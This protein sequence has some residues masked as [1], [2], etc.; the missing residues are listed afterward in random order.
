MLETLVLNSIYLLFPFMLYIIC[1][2]YSSTLNKK[3]SCLLFMFFVI[4]SFYFLV[5]FGKPEISSLPLLLIIIPLL[6]SYTEK[7]LFTILLLNGLTF[8]YFDSIGFSFA[9]SISCLLLCFVLYFIFL[10]CKEKRTIFIIGF[11]V[12]NVIHLLSEVLINSILISPVEGIVYFASYIILPVL[13]VI[14]LEKLK[15]VVN[16]HNVLKTIQKEEK[17]RLSL[18]KITHE[19]K[20]PIAVCKGYLDML[21][22]SDVEQCQKYIPIVRSEI[23]RTLCLLKDFLDLNKVAIEKE[24]LDVGLLMEEIR[25]SCLPLLQ[26]KKIAYKDS[27]KDEDEIYLNGDYNRLKQ[28]FVNVIKNSIE[29]LEGRE[30]P[31]IEVDYACKNNKIHIIVSDNGCG[32]NKETLH[33][34][35]EPFF[36]TK[37]TGTGLGVTISSEII[38]SHKG[39]IRYDSKEGIGT[40]V[41]IILPLS[42]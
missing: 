28:V 40:K 32:M 20:N 24:E 17:F 29:S 23:H 3:M 7:D 35:K 14:L 11:V 41:E 37:A 6:L 30:S 10:N 39:D 8:F 12:I 22:T 33:K 18:F 13:F 5:R 34:I 27:F 16:L 36:T 42:I 19:I 26:D 1:Y 2:M 15:N 25:S 31:C 9:L 4:S 21:D 38:R